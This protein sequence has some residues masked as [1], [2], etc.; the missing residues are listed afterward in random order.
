MINRSSVISVQDAKKHLIEDYHFKII[1][2]E[3]ELA[4]IAQNE[5]I[6]QEEPQVIEQ[7]D[8]LQNSINQIEQKN[9]LMFESIKK[10]EAQIL[11]QNEKINDYLSS[12]LENAKEKFIQEGEQKARADFEIQLENLKE[13]YLKSVAKL[14]EASAKMLDFCQKFESELSQMALSI[15]EE[16]LKKELEKDSK[17]VALALARDLLVE[18]KDANELELRVN[19]KDYEFL[20]EKLEAEFKG[21]LKIVLDD[22]ISRGGVVVLSELGNIDSNLNLRLSKIKKMLLNG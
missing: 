2:N 5:K 6:I 14:D 17:Y 8:N 9:D 16:I 18:L 12:E 13:Q 11:A 3:Q 7:N 15:A 4:N 20:K 19:S 10:L 22:A 21:K 1:Q